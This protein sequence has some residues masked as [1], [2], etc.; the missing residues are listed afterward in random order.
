M[1]IPARGSRLI[2]TA[3]S[4]CP[5]AFIPALS[6]PERVNFSTFAPTGNLRPTPSP[7]LTKPLASPSSSALRLLPRVSG[8]SISP[9]IESTAFFSPFEQR[10]TPQ[11]R[12]ITTFTPLTS[13]KRPINFLW[14]FGSSRISRRWDRWF[15]RREAG[16]QTPRGGG[17]WSREIGRGTFYA[18]RM[19][20]RSSLLPSAMT[21]RTRVSPTSSWFVRPCLGLS[22][23]IT[24]RLL[25]PL[26]A[27]PSTIEERPDSN[28]Q[29]LLRHL[30]AREL[31]LPPSHGPSPP[32]QP[33]FPPPLLLPA[34]AFT[35]MGRLPA[36]ARCDRTCDRHGEALF[37]DC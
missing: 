37:M 18:R 23:W 10:T 17:R 4:Q 33:R 31:P 26:L 15:W 28:L 34:D 16:G 30:D 12:I 1:S 2:S 29:G 24:Q 20:S 8:N 35:A 13:S 21:S 36:G 19:C 9:S 27:L 25:S 3:D 5:A 11:T 7:L 32:T 14:R 22:I 6:P